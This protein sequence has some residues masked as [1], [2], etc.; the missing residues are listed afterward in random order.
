MI[1][2]LLMT[3][4]AWFAAYWVRFYSFFEAEKGIPE[5]FIYVRLGF[6]LLVCSF[7]TFY[8]MGIYE[9]S[10]LRKERWNLLTAC[11]FVL[12]AFVSWTYFF[13]D[14]RHSRKMIG[15]F[16]IFY[17]PFILIGRSLLR[18]IFRFYRTHSY[19]KKSLYIGDSAFFDRAKALLSEEEFEKSHFEMSFFLDQNPPLP[20]LWTE[21]LSSHKIS[22][23]VLAL[24]KDQ[25]W[26][27]RDHFPELS[28]QIPHIQ[29]VPDVSP[30]HRFLPQMEIKKNIPVIPIHESPLA[31]P[32]VILKRLS[33]LVGG[34]L[35]LL[36]FSPV[37]GIAACLVKLSS[38]GP[39]F[40]RQERMGIDGKTFYMLKFRSMPLAAET[41]T[42]AIWA[43]KNDN[44]ATFWGGFLRK[45][46][47]DE[48]PQLFNVLKGDMSLVGP[49]PERPVFVE[50]F[51]SKIPGYMLRHK[52]KAGMTGWAQVNGWR[53]DTSL[54]ERIACD[55]YY[56]RNWSFWLD[57]KILF[58]TPIKGFINPNAY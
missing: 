32:W 37:M 7:L 30:Y 49:R 39:I 11:F 44:R 3:L 25:E 16:F 1:T 15:F 56:I 52:V 40:Y 24:K 12:L 38:P 10:L 23:L 5:F 18:K 9:K 51:R 42:G 46:S 58:L 41:K 13:E 22:A 2:D 35:A 53:G 21:F 8:S 26:F 33:D 28:Q 20:S 54:E 34:L 55:L 4:G 19:Q 47:L 14:M 31:G 50:E 27:Y 17:P 6:F 29:I 36:L 48:L 45:S 43:T 57:M